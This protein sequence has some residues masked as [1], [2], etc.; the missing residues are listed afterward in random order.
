MGLTGFGV[1]FLFFGMMLFF[2]KALLA[3]GNV[4]WPNSHLCQSFS[5]KLNL[6]CLISSCR[7]CLCLACPSL[8]AWSAPSGS[9]SR[10]TRQKPPAFSWEES[11]WFWSA[12]LLLALFW[13]STVSFFYSGHFNLTECASFWLAPWIPTSQI[14]PFICLQGVLP[15]GGRVHQKST[16]AWIIAQLTGD[17]FCKSCVKQHHR[18]KLCT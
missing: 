4:S 11:S 8:S 17:Q 16:C 15:C 13:R 10:G 5:E 1:F 12:G 14:I 6:T 18:W 9:S 2:D 3:I 7:F